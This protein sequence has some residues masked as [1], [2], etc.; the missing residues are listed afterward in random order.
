MLPEWDD[1]PCLGRLLATVVPCFLAMGRVALLVAMISWCGC[2]H[3]A[4][5]GFQWEVNSLLLK[6]LEIQLLCHWP[7]QACTKGLIRFLS[8]LFWFS[9][10]ESALAPFIFPPPPVSLNTSLYIAHVDQN[11]CCILVV[12]LAYFPGLKYCMLKMPIYTS[13]F[14]QLFCQILPGSLMGWV[15]FPAGKV[16]QPKCKPSVQSPGKLNVKQQ[17][18]LTS[19]LV[20]GHQDINKMVLLE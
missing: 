5:L 1:V 2:A 14:R 15:R 10:D 18:G 8:C 4:I 17:E 6:P 11:F 9:P 20:R 19:L 16:R 3:S 13:I 7:K 12:L